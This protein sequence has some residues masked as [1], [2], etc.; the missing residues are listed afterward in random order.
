MPLRQQRS[1]GRAH[2]GIHTARRLNKSQRRS[3][4][5]SRAVSLVEL[6]PPV[7]NRLGDKRRDPCAEDTVRPHYDKTRAQTLPQRQIP[8]TIVEPCLACLLASRSLALASGTT[9]AD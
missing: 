6:L 1:R 5:C 7:G 3:H 9:A 8:G 2:N 4:E